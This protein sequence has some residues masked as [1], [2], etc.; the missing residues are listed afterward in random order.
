MRRFAEKLRIKI[1]W[2]THN[3][4]RKMEIEQRNHG[5]PN[6]LGSTIPV[7]SLTLNHRIQAVILFRIHLP[8]G[9][10]QQCAFVDRKWGTDLCLTSNEGA[11]HASNDIAPPEQ[12]HVNFTKVA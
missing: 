4:P 2:E 1:H 10:A 8:L 6:K 3:S 5:C 7:V 9:I 12:S 11:Q